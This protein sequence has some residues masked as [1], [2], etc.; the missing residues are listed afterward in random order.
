M[1]LRLL[2]MG[3]IVLPFALAALPLQIAILVL[4]LPV[5]TALPQLFFK[6]LAFALG[7]KVTLHG[8]PVR[9]G[10]VLLVAN[11]IGW[12]DIVALA[13][14]MPVAFVAKSDIA[15]WPVVGWLARMQKTIFVDRTRRTDT[16]RTAREMSARISEGVPVLL[17]AEGTS[18]VGTHVLPFRS[19]LMG[20]AGA[21]MAQGSDQKP[22]IQPLAIAYTAI[23][24]LPI[25]RAERRQVAWIGD[26]D[27]SDNL[28]AILSSGPK[29]VHIAFGTPLDG[30]GDRKVVAKQAEDQVRQMLGALN[31]G[32][33][34][35]G[36][37]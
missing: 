19:A 1:A 37:A 3:L 33:P 32:Y 12:L 30:T 31:R 10:P 14:Q 35:P 22:A 25:A 16:G 9:S 13:S 2:F 29:T 34:L 27:I 5:W 21:A 4:K 28:G 18:D 15:R 6:L 7:L 11:H 36:A 26:M 17:F 24:G 20:A 8:T 23:S